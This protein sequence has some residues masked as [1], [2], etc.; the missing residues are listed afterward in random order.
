MATERRATALR[1][2]FVRAQKAPSA[3]LELWLETKGAAGLR[4]CEQ[5]QEGGWLVEWGICGC[6]WGLLRL[7]WAN[8]GP[9]ASWRLP[10]FAQCFL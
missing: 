5:A 2:T 8:D 3:G 6:C 10:S 9:P 4:R 1:A 7:E